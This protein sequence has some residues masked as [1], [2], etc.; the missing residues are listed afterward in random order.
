[1][2]LIQITFVDFH[3]DSLFDGSGVVVMGF[4]YI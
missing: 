4:R 1:M 3:S 2:S